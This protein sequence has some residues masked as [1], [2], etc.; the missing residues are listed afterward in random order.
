MDTSSFVFLRT[1][2]AIFG[3]EATWFSEALSFAYF[4]GFELIDSGVEQL[5]C[6]IRRSLSKGGPLAIFGDCG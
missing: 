4:M 5:L 6:M 2:L 1:V 3:I